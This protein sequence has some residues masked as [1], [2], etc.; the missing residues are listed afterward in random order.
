[1]GTHPIFESDFD[2]LT[3]KSKKEMSDLSGWSN[4]D[5]DVD[6]DNDPPTLSD[7]QDAPKCPVCLISTA[8]N[9]ITQCNH[10]YCLRCVIRMWN[11]ENDELE[12]EDH[13]NP[14]I[15]PM[16]R[17]TVVKL[18]W[19]GKLGN[20]E[21]DEY[22]QRYEEYRPESTQQAT[23]SLP[24]TQK[25]SAAMIILY[26]LLFLQVSPFLSP[27]VGFLYRPSTKAQKNI[28]D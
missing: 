10:A 16:C 27:I 26:L 4:S 28:G 3:V 11:S 9:V 22:N 21:V 24:A 23:R 15:C 19:I 6:S 2:C 14:I 18:T 25:L 12:E 13:L 5:W 7:D 8:L 17:N 1:M 20:I